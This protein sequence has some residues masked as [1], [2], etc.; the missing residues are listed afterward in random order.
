[1]RE[2]SSAGGGIWSRLTRRVATQW[3][4]NMQKQCVQRD[5]D[6]ES[7]RVAIACEQSQRGRAGRSAG[8]PEVR[9]DN[10]KAR[11]ESRAT[12]RGCGVDGDSRLYYYA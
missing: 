2:S 3:H 7:A 5:A 8:Q 6:S 1:M 4:T 9:I 10:S 11:D 12:G